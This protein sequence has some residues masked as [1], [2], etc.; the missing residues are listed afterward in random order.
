MWKA[1]DITIRQEV[2]RCLLCY[3]APCSKA[4]PAQN[5]PDKFIRSLFLKNVAGA[6]R[7]VLAHNILAE[8]CAASCKDSAY[9]QNACIRKRIDKAVDIPLLQKHLAG[10]AKRHH[11]LP[12]CA[13]SCGKTVVILG[14]GPAGMTA[15]AELVKQGVKVTMY[16]DGSDKSPQNLEIESMRR[17]EQHTIE[18]ELS[19]IK[20][21]GILVKPLPTNQMDLNYAEF[22]AG[23]I[24]SKRYVKWLQPYGLEKMRIFVTGELLSDAGGEVFAVKK[25]KEIA[26]QVKRFLMREEKI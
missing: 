17:I 26:V 16:I 1:S 14:A 5:Q 12:Q 10:Y 3:D 6:A 8:S 9:C 21:M 20:E 25:G 13:P 22:D 7:S 15:A 23:I 4:C 18:S 24:S 19:L 2:S 11:C